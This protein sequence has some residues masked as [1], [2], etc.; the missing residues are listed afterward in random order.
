MPKVPK[1]K[2]KHTHS[3]KTHLCKISTYEYV[4]KSHWQ[5]FGTHSETKSDLL[6]H[7]NV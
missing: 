6:S 3:N 1:K 4:N 5:R 7:R 2:K